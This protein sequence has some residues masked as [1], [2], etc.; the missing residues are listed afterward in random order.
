MVLFSVFYYYH[1]V[2][3]THTGARVII[4]MV[5][6]RDWR[7]LRSPKTTFVNRLKIC[8]KIILRHINFCLK[9]ILTD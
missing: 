4:T 8:L 3:K 5:T 7:Q 1:C 2:N 6:R 9:I